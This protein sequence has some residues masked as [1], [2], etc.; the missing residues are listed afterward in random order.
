MKRLAILAA[1][2]AFALETGASAALADGCAGY[3]CANEDTTV[4]TP[5]QDGCG[6]NGCAV[7]LQTASPCPTPYRIQKRRNPRKR[8]PHRP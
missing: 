3:G 8:S 1:L 2:S 5:P 7:P 4:S 6:T